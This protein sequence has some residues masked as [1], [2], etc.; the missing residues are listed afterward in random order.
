MSAG[1]EQVYYVN[2]NIIWSKTFWARLKTVPSTMTNRD[3][4]I[5]FD[6]SETEEEIKQ[7]IAEHPHSKFLV[8][9]GSIDKVL[10]LIQ[11]TFCYAYWI[12]NFYF[13]SRWKKLL[14]TH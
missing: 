1:A 7:K 14:Q 6:C 12:S 5:Y 11:K 13:F 2:R 8:C 9:D 3:S 10:K 4:I